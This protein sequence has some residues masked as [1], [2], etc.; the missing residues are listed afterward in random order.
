MTMNSELRV[1]TGLLPHGGVLCA[2][3]GGADS[4]CLLHWLKSREAE[5]D[6]RVYAAHYEHGLRGEESLRDCAFVEAYCRE[7]GIPCTVEHGDVRGYAARHGLG[8]EEA[9]RALRYDFLE[10]TAD[11]LGCGRIATAHNADDNAETLLLHLVR[12]SGTAGLCGI[13][14]ERGRIVRPLLGCTRAEIER[15]LKENGLAHVEDGSN[16]DEAFSRNRLRLRVMP[17]LRELNP[18][19]AEA[20]GRTA[21]LLREDD[22]CLRALARDFIAAQ[23]RDESLPLAALQALHPAVAGRVLRALCPESLSRA[24]VDAALRF[25]SDTALGWLDLPGLRLRRERGRLYF[26]GRTEPGEIPPRPL[27]PGTVTEVPEARLRIRS[28]LSVYTGAEIHSE[29]KTLCFKCENIYG[30]VFCTSRRPGDRMRPAG[31]NLTKSLKALFL[32]AGMTQ[33]ERDKTPVFRDEAGVLAVYGLARDERSLP[34]PG[35]RVLRLEIE[36]TEDSGKHG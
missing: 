28:S 17:V 13:P 3:S 8:L 15:Y 22:A 16:G 14:P 23:Y 10:R 12:G 18:S 2:V 20:A 32:E 6:I 4:M 27:T 7:R 31:R 33:R 21:Q 24:H 35:D 34:E 36:R 25:V 30:S 9:A 19:F 26:D 1:E 29:F 11:A 5:L